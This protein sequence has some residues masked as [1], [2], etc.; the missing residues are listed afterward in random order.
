MIPYDRDIDISVLGSAEPKLRQLSTTR[1]QIEDGQFNLVLRPGPHCIHSGGIRQN[2]Y[3][4]TVIHQ[5]DSCA[6]CHPVARVFHKRRV[7]LDLFLFHLEMRFDD[8]QQPIQ[9]GYFDES[10]DLFGSDLHCL[11]P[12]KSCK[13][14]G[15]I[16]P[17]PRDPATLLSLHYGKDFMKPR[18]WCNLASRHWV[19]SS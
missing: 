12:L 5:S 8:E 4:R 18:R 6:F 11:F 14:L 7:C 17:C 9:F 2:C 15:L 19:K 1:G 3:G 13:F 16:V 10:S